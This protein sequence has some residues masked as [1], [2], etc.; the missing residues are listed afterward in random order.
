MMNNKSSKHGARR[1]GTVFTRHY[2]FV[3]AGISFILSYALL[4]IILSGILPTERTFHM[5]VL[6]D[7][8]TI[9]FVHVL[10]L[11]AS[12]MVAYYV[13]SGLS[14]ESGDNVFDER[15]RHI[16]TEDEKRALKEI[17]KSKSISQDSLRFRLGWSKAKTSSIVTRLEKYRLI[18]RERIG[19]TYRLVPE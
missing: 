19:K 7:Y 3:V 13:Y 18:Q 15:I 1:G 6:P 9:I 8:N 11:L 12:S 2:R 10:S 5:M 16:L 14:P 17:R 4:Y